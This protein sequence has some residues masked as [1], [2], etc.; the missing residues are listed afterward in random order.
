MKLD[1][2]DIDLAH[3]GRQH[4][5]R[6]PAVAARRRARAARRAGRA[7][8]HPRAHADRPCWATPT[9]SGRSRCCCN[10]ASRARRWRSKA[11][12]LKRKAG[13][14]STSAARSRSRTRTSISTSCSTSCRWPG[15][16]ASRS[17]TS[18]SAASPARSCTS[19]AAPIVPSWPATS[20]WPRSWSAASSSAPGISRCRRRPSAP[21]ASPASPSTAGC[22]IASTSTRRRRWRPRARRSRRDRLPARRDRG[23]GARAGRVRRR[24]RHRQRP[25][26]ASTSIRRAR[27]R[28]TSCSPS[29]GCRWRAPSRAPTARRPSSG[30]RVEA[31]RPLH[32]SVNGDR[33]VLDEAHFKT[34]G[35]DL[36]VAGRLDGKRD[37]GQSVRAPRPGAAAAVPGRGQPARALHGGLNVRAPGR[38][39]RWTSRT[40]AARWPS[41]TPSAC[42]PRTSIAT[43]SSARASSRS[44]EEGVAV[45]NL[46]VTIDGST[47]RLGGR[48]DAGTGVRAREHPG[49]RRRRRQRPPARVRR[50][51]RRVGR[52]GQGPRAR[53]RARHAGR[54]RRSAAGWISAPS[55]FACATW[56]RRCRCRAASSRSATRASSCT[57]CASCWTTRACWSSAPRACAPGGSS[58]RA[59]SRSSS[60]EF[61]LP[62]HG[63]RITYRSPG[64]FEVDDLA[65]RPR[66][67]RQHGGRLRAGRRGPA[68]VR[69]VPAGLQDHGPGDQPARQRVDGAP[70]LRGQAA[71][72]EPG[73]GPQRAHRRRGLHRPEQHRA[74]DPRRHPA[75]R[76]RHPVA[77]PSSRAT[78][79]RWTA[80]STSRSCAATS[81]WSP[82]STT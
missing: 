3:A 7:R 8:H 68:G 6:G 57:T 31:A 65:L 71:A 62:L 19:A 79:A 49:R 42:A 14:T 66:H 15:C 39:A 4:R 27:W 74:R 82:T 1:L 40:C 9:C 78:S 23:A 11:L 54:S 20:T 44:I 25:R 47:M 33:V 5:R 61:D 56:G 16:P 76:R 32:V 75:A 29:C 12:H 60:G 80:A 41:P 34:D 43:W 63:E 64:V 22:S 26:H 81:T 53:A 70:V 28:W 69:A 30:V 48:A 59:W 46:A 50:A 35:G 51:R 10:T 45:Q 13:G 24:A 58:S 2:R 37:L 38:A 55:T 52:A 36:V 17:R 72:R 77:S 21:A 18:R 73:A 67:E